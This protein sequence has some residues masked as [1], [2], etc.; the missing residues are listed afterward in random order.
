MHQ[1]KTENPGFPAGFLSCAVPCWAA[2][3]PALPFA[4]VTPETSALPKASG[5]HILV[6]ILLVEKPCVCV[7]QAC[8]L[9]A[10]SCSNFAMFATSSAAWVAVFSSALRL[11][12]YSTFNLVEDKPLLLRCQS[13]VLRL[14]R[15]GRSRQ[16]TNLLAPLAVC[17]SCFLHRRC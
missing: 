5:G 6:I 9:Q 8:H 15:L 10:P 2:P 3:S 1:P 16:A 17:H 7:S 11:R 14:P 12:Q 13:G 4:A